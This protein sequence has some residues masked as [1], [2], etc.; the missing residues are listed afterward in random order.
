MASGERVRRS[1]AERT[2]ESGRR[3]LDAAV[4]LI[5]EQGFDRTTTADIGERAGYSRGMVRNRYG[6]KE[7]LLQTLLRDEVAARM[8]PTVDSSLTGREQILSRLEHVCNLATSSPDLLRAFFVLCFEALGPVDVLRPWVDEWFE[9]YEL[10]T[11]A[12]VS[13]GIG[14]GSIRDGAV[15]EVEAKEI[16]DFGIGLTFRWMLK[17]DGSRLEAE[18][19]SWQKRLAVTY[20]GDPV[21]VCTPGMQVRNRRQLHT[22]A[23]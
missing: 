15:P 20:S 6:S 13:A 18:L 22:V 4:A 21:S 17:R 1:Q 7:A 8:L 3:L 9:R 5:A 2:E 23:A 10:E 14:D 12:S 19:A 11:L 16:V